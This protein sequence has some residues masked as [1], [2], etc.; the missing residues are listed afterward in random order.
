M[1]TTADVRRPAQPHPLASHAPMHR[2][3]RDL[4]AA[5]W[6]KLWS[7]RSTYLALAAALVAT[8]TISVGVALGQVGYVQSGQPH[9]PFEVDPMAVTF[10]GIAVA[11]LLLGILGALSITGEYGSGLVRT[12]FS[13][14]P[15][16]GRV[17]V[18][19]ATVVAA[20]AVIFGQVLC[21]GLFL[22]VQA[23]LARIHHDLGI[24][25]PG[26]VRAIVGAGVYLAVVTL[27]GLGIGAIVRHT[28]AA[29]AAIVVMFFL[30]PQVPSAL[31]QPWS[32]RLADVM[33]STAAQEITTLS[34]RADLLSINQSYLLLAAYA[35]FVPVL[36]VYLVR[37]RDA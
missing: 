12:T 16:R 36:G 15:Q 30:I 14:T 19:K 28:A 18:A 27:V 17:L 37:R 2:Q 6:I 24:H 1:T 8:P 33:P 21:F 11:Q 10:R 31:P 7:V 5:E 35:L 13:A 25:H 23:T 26:V 29:I 20:T 3:F 22:A 9:G 34:P 4:I 32:T